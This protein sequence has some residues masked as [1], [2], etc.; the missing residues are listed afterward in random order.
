MEKQVYIWTDGA[1]KKNPGP[2]G[3]GAVIRWGSI[4]KE[5]FGGEPA[6]TNNRMELMA[7]IQALEAL[8]RPTQTVIVTDSQYVKQGITEW[9]H[10]WKTNGWRTGSGSVKN[11]DL[12]MRLE[13]ATSQH[14]IDWQWVKGHSGHTENTR[15][16]RLAARGI[17]L[18]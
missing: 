17:K 2:G 1:C 15:A 9:I 18:G 6:T 7:V 8:T 4:E 14:T 5:L 16:D 10:R 3:W 12:W 11:Q 13:Q